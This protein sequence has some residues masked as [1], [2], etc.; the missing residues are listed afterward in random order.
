MIISIV[1]LI[2]S[3]LLENIMGNIFPSYLGQASY[4]TTI[5]TIIAL[6]IIYPYFISEK[7]ISY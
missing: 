6:V 1:Y 2:I 7:N 4:F 3:F 5:Y